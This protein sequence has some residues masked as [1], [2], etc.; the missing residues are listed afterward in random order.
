MLDHFDLAK[1]YDQHAQAVF[2]Y[3]LNLTRHEADTRDLL[4]DLFVKLARQPSLLNGVS[5][6]RP[7]LLRLAHNA[8]IDL[9]RRAATRRRHQDRLEA[10]PPRLFESG[11]DPDECGFRQ[12][13]E[14]AL[15]DLPADQRAVV[16]LK[17]WENQTFE[18]I[19]QTLDIPLNTAASRFR[20][21][22]DKLRRRLRPLYDEIK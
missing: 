10:A 8:A 18:A 13:L 16:Y 20:Y 19:A 22:L 17:L 6:V 7:F 2:G 9:L 21:G 3:L 12:G 4:Q 5:Q 15:G 11:P 14:E 1:I